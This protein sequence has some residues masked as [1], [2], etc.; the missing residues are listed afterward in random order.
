[1]VRPVTPSI[2]TI[3]QEI[4][5]KELKV[6]KIQ[7][8]ALKPTINKKPKIQKI[9]WIWQHFKEFS[10][11]TALHGYNHIVRNDSTKCER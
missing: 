2:P 1:M 9:A 4:S 5:G 8:K 6:K 3:S 11:N 7:V 10:E